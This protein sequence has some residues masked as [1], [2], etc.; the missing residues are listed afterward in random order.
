VFFLLFSIIFSSDG[1][2][3][4]TSDDEIKKMTEKF[5]LCQLKTRPDFAGY[6]FDVITE[7]HKPLGGHYIGKVHHQFY[8]KNAP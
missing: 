7:R 6:G 1:T 2:A 8:D 4:R 3:H 5:R